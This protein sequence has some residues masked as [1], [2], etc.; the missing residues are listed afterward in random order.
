MKNNSQDMPHFRWQDCI[1]STIYDFAMSMK[2]I[3]RFGSGD[4]DAL[5]KLLNK[6]YLASRFPGFSRGFEIGSHGRLLDIERGSRFCVCV[7]P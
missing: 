3:K 5:G 1:R 7:R 6:N 4:V 2:F